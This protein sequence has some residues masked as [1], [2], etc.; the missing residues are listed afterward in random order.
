M[1]QLIWSLDD[2]RPGLGGPV[3]ISIAVHLENGDGAWDGVLQGITYEQSMEEP[4]YLQGVLSGS[5]DYA[6][7]SAYIVGDTNKAMR[8]PFHVLIFPGDMPEVP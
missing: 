6:G 1:P 7:Q 4:G 8:L 3:T 2:F 5:G